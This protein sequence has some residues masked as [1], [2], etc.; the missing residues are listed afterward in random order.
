MNCVPYV[1]KNLPIPGGGYVTGFLYSKKEKDV[2]YARTDIG[3]TYRFDVKTQTWISLIPHV[4]MEDLSETFP[5]SFAL[6]EEKPGRLCIACGVNAE[7]SGVLAISEDYG[8]CFSYERIPVRVHG[9]LNGRGTGERLYLEGNCIWFGSQQEGL[10]YSMDLGKTWEKKT[11]MTEEYLTFVTKLGELLLVGTAGVTTGTRPS[12]EASGADMTPMRGHSLYISYDEGN[13]FEMLEEPVSN[14]IE[15]CRYHGQVAQRWCADDKYLYVT[16]ASTG[17]NSYVLENGY[18]CDSGDCIDGHIVRYELKYREGVVCGLGE[19]E[20]IT[21]GSA[22]DVKGIGQERISRGDILKYGFSGI[23]VSEQTSGML[24]ATTVVKYDGD[25]IFLSMDYGQSWK[26]VL[27][28]LAEG[29][30]TFRAPYMRPECNGGHSLIH[31]LSDIKINPF[32]DNEAWFN[33]GTGVFRTRNLK[34]EV[35]EFTDWCD[36]I[37]ETVHLNVYSMPGGEVQVID[38]LG[39]LGGFAFTQLD[40]PCSNS[41]ADARGNR[42][43]TCINAD[44]S[45]EHPEWLV[46]T[47]R[48]NWT[49]K[50]KGGLILSKDQGRTFERLPMPFGLTEDLDQA[51]HQIETPNVNSGWVAMSPD[52]Q[53]IVWSV[54]D[55]IQLPVRRVVS[56]RDGGKIFACCEIFDRNGNK[57]TDGRMKVFSD[58]LDSELFYGFGQASDFYI[59]KDGGRTYRE[60]LLPAEFPKTE[61]GL[62]DCA[63]KTEVRGEAGKTGV[64]YLCIGA[65][66]LWKLTYHKAE[67]RVQLQR[68]TAPGI[69][70]YR[71]GLGLGT[72]GGDYFRDSKMV[73]FNGVVDGNYGFY[74][75]GDEGK[76]FERLNTDRQ[77]FGEINSIDGDCRKYGRFFLATGSNGIKY[78]EMA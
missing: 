13:T 72:P 63:N 39:D 54:A 14:A 19:M 77:M 21:P 33:S 7:K 60:Y 34:A 4:T 67:D 30:M 50:T 32:D 42:Y 73:Y 28:D 8:E 40:K 12:A 15:G 78:G 43:I 2:L 6:D 11:A 29:K 66:G 55:G 68:L 47:P 61:F 23:S 20:E 25:S 74:R 18:S 44:F 51:L 70:V 31:W 56:S 48:G 65:E 58:R 9:N 24:V 75:T 1:Y 22:S 16:F 35:C 41:F 38:I 27:Y 49:G 52:G 17:R 76:T 69:S 62:I 5:I 26:Q 36:G 37:E 59:S 3:G 45:D 71:M 46:V 57:K 10:W 64:F 53:N